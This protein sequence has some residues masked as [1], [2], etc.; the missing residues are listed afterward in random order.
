MQMR[1]LLEYHWICKA[2]AEALTLAFM[3]ITQVSIVL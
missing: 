3:L 1:C 2:A